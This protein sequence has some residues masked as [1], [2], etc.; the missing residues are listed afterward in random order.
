M[1]V[2]NLKD[3]DNCEKLGHDWSGIPDPVNNKLDRIP[4]ID[5]ETGKPTGKYSSTSYCVRC[6][7]DRGGWRMPKT[8]WDREKL[9]KTNQ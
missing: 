1:P 4:I 2:I 5:G 7:L 8:Y 3:Y 9:N 6:N